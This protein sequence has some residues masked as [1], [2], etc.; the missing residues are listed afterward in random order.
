M[1]DYSEAERDMIATLV[2]RGLEVAQEGRSV[3]DDPRFASLSAREAGQVKRLIYQ[4]IAH[5]RE[6]AETATP[7]PCPDVPTPLHGQEAA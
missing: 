7:S 1:L 4:R 5:L 6:H 3:G 2:D